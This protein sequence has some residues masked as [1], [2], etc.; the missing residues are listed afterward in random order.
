M[1]DAMLLFQKF[2]MSTAPLPVDAVFCWQEGADHNSSQGKAFF[3]KL[4]KN[5]KSVKEATHT[6]LKLSE[7]CGVCWMLL[8][9]HN[10]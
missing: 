3:F 4:E 9:W 1:T 2:L 5:F 7:D 10:P 8:A 6:F